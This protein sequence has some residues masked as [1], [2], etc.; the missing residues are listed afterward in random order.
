MENVENTLS[1]FSWDFYYLSENSNLTFEFIQK[2][3]DKNWSWF[4]ISRH[5]CITFNIIQKY[6]QFP[7]DWDGISKN[8]NITMDIVENNLDKKWNFYLLSWNP[9]L[10]FEFVNKYNNYYN[11]ML[12]NQ[13]KLEKENIYNTYITSYIIR[14]QRWWRKYYYSVEFAKK[15]FEKNFQF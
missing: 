3:I 9:N 4:F 15:D 11:Y 8:P 1:K 14:I 7:W 12:S 13:F 2:H 5:Q 6:S 10:T